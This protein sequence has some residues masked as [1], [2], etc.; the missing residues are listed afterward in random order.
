MDRFVTATPEDE[1]AMSTTP[2]ATTLTQLP[3]RN[4]A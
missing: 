3:A 1:V 4:F 2:E